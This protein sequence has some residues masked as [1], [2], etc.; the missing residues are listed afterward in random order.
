MN[1]VLSM[2]PGDTIPHSTGKQGSPQTE[3]GRVLQLSSGGPESSSYTPERSLYPELLTQLSASL[4]EQWS[5]CSPFS[6]GWMQHLSNYGTL[7][8]ICLE[9]GAPLAGTS[10]LRRPVVPYEGCRAR[11]YW[12]ILGEL[13]V[14]RPQGLSLHLRS[15]SSLRQSG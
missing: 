13:E 8:C 9:I 12:G 4:S 14:Q 6:M 11:N 1:K 15:D 7:I 5:L 10:C 2:S 3:K